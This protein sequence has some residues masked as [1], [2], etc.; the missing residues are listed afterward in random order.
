MKKI[1]LMASALVFSAAMFAQTPTTPAP[2]QK[3]TTAVKPT[4]PVTAATDKDK[5]KGEH[6]GKGK[7]HHKGVKK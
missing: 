7:G 5:G 1:M 4:K 3:Q 2:A 6:H